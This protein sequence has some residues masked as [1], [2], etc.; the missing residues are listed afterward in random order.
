[1]TSD[2]GAWRQTIFYHYMHASV[3]GRGTVLN[4]L[5]QAPVYES[6]TYGE[7]SCLDSVCIWNEEE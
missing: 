3:F 1:M 7:V 4:T 5:V 6:K 2:K